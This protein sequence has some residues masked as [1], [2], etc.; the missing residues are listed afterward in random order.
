MGVGVV[1]ARPFSLQGRLGGCGP[2]APASLLDGHMRGLTTHWLD[3]A[4]VQ[5][6]TECQRRQCL[7]AS[8]LCGSVGPWL[9]AS[10][11]VSP[12]LG[13]CEGGGSGSGVL[14]RKVRMPAAVQPGAWLPRL[15]VNSSVN[16]T[17]VRHTG[18]GILYFGCG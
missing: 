1:P 13:G 17:D 7:M 5:Q 8:S 12:L 11:A 6:R 3:N 9:L 18:G 10:G 14:L 16:E 2:G 4:A 15:Q